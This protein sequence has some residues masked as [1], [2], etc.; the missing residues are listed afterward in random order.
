[1]SEQKLF[2]AGQPD[3]SSVAGQTDHETLRHWIQ[4]V[5][6]EYLEIP[7]LHLTRSQVE[8]LWGLDA[9]SCDQILDALI[10][11][12]FLSRT[13]EGGFLRAPAACAPAQNEASK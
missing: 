3:L 6:G 11:A 7:G 5:R 2:T 4:A 1:L 8:R 10:E 12:Q 13:R 9:V